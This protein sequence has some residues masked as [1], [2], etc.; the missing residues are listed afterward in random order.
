MSWNQEVAENQEVHGNKEV[1]ED[2]EER[3]G[4][5]ISDSELVDASKYN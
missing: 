4:V 2:E 1:D 5:P 3:Y